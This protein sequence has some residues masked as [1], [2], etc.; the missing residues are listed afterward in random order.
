MPWGQHAEKARERQ[1]SNSVSSARLRLEQLEAQL[2]LDVRLA[3]R[4]VETNLVSVEI[5]AKATELASRQFDQQKARFDAGLST[6]RIV[7]QFQ[8][9]LENARISELQAKLALRR[10]VAELRRLEGTSLQRFRL[11]VE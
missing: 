4:A 7:L 11:P 2:M 8:D 10:A 9:D 6:S 1:A 5:A 3:V